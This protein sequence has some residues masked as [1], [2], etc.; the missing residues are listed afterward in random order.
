MLQ[1]AAMAAAFWLRNSTNQL[2]V[3]PYLWEEGERAEQQCTEQQQGVGCWCGDPE[4]QGYLIRPLTTQFLNWTH[5]QPDLQGLYT[6][7]T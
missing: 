5:C 3:W 2:G 7:S 4:Q 1:L 6:L